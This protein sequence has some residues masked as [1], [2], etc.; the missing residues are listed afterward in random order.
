MHIWPADISQE[1]AQLSLRLQM[2]YTHTP[3]L[4]LQLGSKDRW[5]SNSKMK[6]ISINRLDVEDSV[7]YAP[8]IN[9]LPTSNSFNLWLANT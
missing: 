9:S 8:L 1:K 7:S 4:K 5:W 6:G 2:F 3:S